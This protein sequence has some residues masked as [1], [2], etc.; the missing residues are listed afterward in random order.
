[1][2]TIESSPLPTADDVVELETHANWR[3]AD[4]GDP[5]DWTLRLS[6]ADHAELD[7][8]LAHA[9]SVT[10]EVLDVTVDDF[11]LPTLAPRLTDLA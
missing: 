5:D 1:M 11:P 9:R 2:S 8:A 10:D 3:A 4:V 6:D 7:A